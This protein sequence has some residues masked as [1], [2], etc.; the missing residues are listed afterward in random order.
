MATDLPDNL[1]QYFAAQNAHDV[2]SMV[3]RFAPEA[4]VKDE[5][6]TYAGRDAIR[7]W[8]RETS[9]KYHVSVEP[10]ST[11]E[12]DDV[13]TVVARVAGN[14]PGSPAN[15]TYDFVLDRAGLIQRLEI[16]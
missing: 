9:A 4:E 1:L 11:T 13:L 8:M 16:H 2:D 7:E 6:R 12:K 14:F 3:A 15:L 5:G 10:L